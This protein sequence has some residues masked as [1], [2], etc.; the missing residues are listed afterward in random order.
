MKKTKI[1]PKIL[2]ALLAALLLSSFVISCGSE[3]PAADTTASLQ[4]TTAAETEAESTEVPDNLPADL[5]FGGKSFRWCF[6]RKNI[7]YRA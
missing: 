3:K 5:D 1:S 7:A 6:R 4:E 2:S